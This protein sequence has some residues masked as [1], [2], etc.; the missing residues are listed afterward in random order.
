MTMLSAIALA[1][2]A[3]TLMITAVIWFVQVVHYP[4]FARVGAEAFAAYERAHVAR[5]T[6]I[7]APL[8]LV[9]VAT[10]VLLLVSSPSWAS[11]VELWA[12][13]GLLGVA[14]VSTALLQVPSHDRLSMGFDAREIRGLVLGNWIRTVVWTGRGAL[15]IVW[16]SRW[17]SC[18]L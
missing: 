1:H 4:L 3:T 15:V 6:R 2:V 7:V 12:A 14:W 9:E 13:A 17:L 10:T 11:P 5:V 8:M 16:L 18:W